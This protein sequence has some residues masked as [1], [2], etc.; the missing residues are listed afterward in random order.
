MTI[1]MYKDIENNKFINE[2]FIGQNVLNAFLNLQ[3]SISLLTHS[4]K[5][6]VVS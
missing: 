6:S 5:T 4:V 3:M 2:L 1:K